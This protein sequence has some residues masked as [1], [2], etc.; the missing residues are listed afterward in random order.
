MKILAIDP[1]QRRIGVAISDPNGKVAFPLT[2]IPHRSKQEDAERIL[3]LA[4]EHQVDLI[5]IGQALGSN[6]EPTLQS[7]RSANLANAIRAHTAIPVIL[8]D[9]FETTATVMNARREM[10]IRTKQRDQRIDAFA[11]VVLLQSYIENEIHLNHE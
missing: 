7:R 8:I 6:Q 4:E 10:G 9:E 2:V 11:A 1:G 3:A 5:L